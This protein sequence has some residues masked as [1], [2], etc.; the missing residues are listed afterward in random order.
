M[1]GGSW[2]PRD[3]APNYINRSSVDGGTCSVMLFTG[4][5]GK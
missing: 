3:P 1:N 2:S 4:E 5:C